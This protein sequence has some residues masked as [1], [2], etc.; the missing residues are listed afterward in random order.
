VGETGQGEKDK[1]QSFRTSI[2]KIKRKEKQL[3]SIVRQ[4]IR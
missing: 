1:R 2:D 3:G 4:K